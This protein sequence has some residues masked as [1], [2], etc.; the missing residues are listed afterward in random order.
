M[1][2]IDLVALSLLRAP[3]SRTPRSHL[4]VSKRWTAR[5]LWLVPAHTVFECATHRASHL[6]T[7]PLPG[8]RHASP[9]QLARSVIDDHESAVTLGPLP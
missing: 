2:G 7:L 1:L 4:R 6:G 5:V 8:A 9:E 3:R